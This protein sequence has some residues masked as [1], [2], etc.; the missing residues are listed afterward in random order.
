M[1]L[2]PPPCPKCLEERDISSIENPL[3]DR[4]FFSDA[5]PRWECNRCG[6][7]YYGAVYVPDASSRGPDSGSA[8]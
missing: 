6:E 4:L 7:K 2:I 8:G 1:R 5:P 3:L